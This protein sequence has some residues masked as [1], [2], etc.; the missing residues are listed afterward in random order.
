[1]K[2]FIA[3][4]AYIALAPVA[5]GVLAGVDRRLTARLQRRVGPP[6]LQPFYDLYKL[7]SKEHITASGMSASRLYLAGYLLFTVLSGGIFFS[8]G[9]MLI[10][11]F[12][13]ALGSIFLVLGAFAASSPY[14]HLGAE[15]ELL[16]LM[17]AEPMLLIAALGLY[18]ATKSFQV[19]DVLAHPQV[20]AAVLPG[21][22]FGLL[23]VFTIKLRKSPFDLSTSHHA[24]Q[25]L[26]KGLTTEFSGSSLALSEITHWYEIVL[27]LGFIYLFFAA[28]PW[29]GL[30][31]LILA[32]LAEV[33]L[34]NTTARIKWQGTLRSAWLVSA[35]AGLI[36]LGVLQFL[37][38]GRF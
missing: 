17:A 6:L 35:A 14:S 3:G 36:N 26:V 10:S 32:Y 21:I 24:H 31:F 11:L 12:A 9:D 29:L 2:N 18:A 22:L 13:L 27:L 30:V 28:I 4:A 1:M 38:G 16:L 8:G 20:A 7:F 25:E 33:W 19:D 23:Y 37:Q 34:D 5:A 15:R